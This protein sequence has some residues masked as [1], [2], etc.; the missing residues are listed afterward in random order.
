MAPSDTSRLELERAVWERVMKRLRVSTR[1]L[2]LVLI[3]LLIRMTASGPS[4]AAEV[5]G[6]IVAGLLLASVLLT[7]QGHQIEPPTPA[8]ARRPSV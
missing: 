2:S 5:A 7:R 8:V 3:A 6:A 1:V 4:V